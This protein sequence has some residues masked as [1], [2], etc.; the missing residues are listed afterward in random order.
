MTDN[1]YQKKIAVISYSMSVV[2]QG[3][4]KKDEKA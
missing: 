2:G 3:K 1:R 4:E